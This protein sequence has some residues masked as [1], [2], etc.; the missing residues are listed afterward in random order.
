MLV[1]PQPFSLKEILR[2]VNPAPSLAHCSSTYPDPGS[3]RCYNNEMTRITLLI[4]LA[5]SCVMAQDWARTK[6]E[7]LPR[8]REWVTVKHDGRNV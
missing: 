2:N 5:A 8:H 3:T 4:A 7:K 1:G 6:L